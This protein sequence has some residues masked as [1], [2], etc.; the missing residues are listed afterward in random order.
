PDGRWWGQNNCM[1]DYTVAATGYAWIAAYKSKR[2]DRDVSSY[3]DA[4][5]NAINLALGLEESVCA[6]RTGSTW[7]PT[8]SR[9]PCN[10]TVSDLKNNLAKVISLNHGQQTIAYGLG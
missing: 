3:A 7:S 9:G 10:A 8:S 6:Y 2:G 1:D 5:K 4:A